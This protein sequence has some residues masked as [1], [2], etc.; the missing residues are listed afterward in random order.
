VI[1]R[2]SQK[3][4]ATKMPRASDSAKKE[5]T[6][7][8]TE[9]V[10]ISSTAKTSSSEFDGDDW[11]KSGGLSCDGRWESF[12]DGHVPETLQSDEQGMHVDEIGETTN[13][14]PDRLLAVYPDYVEDRPETLRVY[15]GF[16]PDSVVNALYETTRQDQQPWGTYVSIQQVRA[17]WE[18]QKSGNQDENHKYDSATAQNQQQERN[19]LAL[20]ATASFFRAAL[21]PKDAASLSFVKE[22]EAAVPE[23]TPMKE[24]FIGS[25]QDVKPEFWTLSDLDRIHGVAVWGLGAQKSSQVTYHL[26]YAEQVRYET[27]RIVPPAL[28]GTLQCTPSKIIGGDYC[29][30]MGGLQHYQRFGYKGIKDASSNVLKTLDTDPS[31]VRIPYKH[32]RLT[33]QSGHLPHLSTPIESIGATSTNNT[34]RVIVGF[35]VFFP[36]IG[37]LVQR[38]PEHSPIF[39]RK[40][41]LQRWLLSKTRSTRTAPP[42]PSTAK[43]QKACGQG[44]DLSNIRANPALAKL[45]VLAK[46]QK[47]KDEF[48]ERQADLDRS[49]EKAFELSNGESNAC[50]DDPSSGALSVQSLM[51]QLGRTDGQFPSPVDVQVHL[52]HAHLR[53]KLEVVDIAGETVDGRAT[54]NISFL[55]PSATIRI[56]QSASQ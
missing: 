26:D 49:I 36:D 48:R 23:T 53:G 17:Y 4:W 24:T 10:S 51:D 54:N 44:M 14:G 5:M 32:N 31:W 28:A 35:N 19:H 2:S 52:H 50:T 12:D 11:K 43:R 47:V 40:V 45:L 27:N 8:A 29:A 56:L 34:K 1:G 55:S 20:M 9:A 15:D 7:E 39:R 18:E 41:A 13:N 3:S 22:G 38:A 46:R 25:N 21:S 6:M 42:S 16:V 33:I 30:H 37:P